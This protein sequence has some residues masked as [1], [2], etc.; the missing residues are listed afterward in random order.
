[1]PEQIVHI[2]Y[3]KTAS[4]WFQRSVYPRA[5]NLPYVAR[6]QV[7]DAFVDTPALRFDPAAARRELGLAGQHSPA[8]LC[9]EELSGY[10]HHG[11]FMGL[12]SAAVAERLAATLPNAAIVIFIR[13]QPDIIAAC[14]QQYVRGGGTHRPRRY[15]FAREYVHGALS[16]PYKVPRFSFE[17]FEYAPLI[18][19][20]DRLFGRER[21]HVFLYEDLKENPP[22]F[23][24]DFA[25][26]L[27]LDLPIEELSMS[28]RNA[29]Y[30][31]AIVR[32]ARILNLFTARTVMDKTTL[33]HLPYWY[34][35]R[36]VLL[37]AL[38]HARP[39][40]ASPSP[41]ALLGDSIAAYIAGRY[42]ESN[43]ELVRERGLNLARHGYPL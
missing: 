36:R 41:S 42:P 27:D 17:H 40:R 2:G 26:R 20:Y 23:L 39:G 8:I 31:L 37:E 12:T 10:L 25:Q 29:S 30:S 4:T 43:R 19:R 5:R 15:L 33:I 22:A 9:E 24:K 13:R 16:K 1:M 14:Y 32:L 6:H 11:G 35:L 21:V 7:A 3:H 28:P 38:N 34:A 18:R